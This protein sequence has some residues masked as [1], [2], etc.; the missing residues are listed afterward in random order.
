MRTSQLGWVSCMGPD[1]P[2]SRIAK[3]EASRLHLDPWTKKEIPSRR[4]IQMLI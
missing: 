3:W 2:Y 4:M 1:L